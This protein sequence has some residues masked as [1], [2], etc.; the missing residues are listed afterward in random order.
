MEPYYGMIDY[1]VFLSPAFLELGM[2]AQSRFGQLIGTCDRM[3]VANL[4][5]VWN[6]NR[7]KADLMESLYKSELIWP[8]DAYY[9]FIPCV[10]NAN[11]KIRSGKYKSGF[12]KIGFQACVN[13]YPE[14]LQSMTD[15]EKDY[16][17]QH[18]IMTNE[19]IEALTFTQKPQAIEYNQASFEENNNDPSNYI[20][21][22]GVCMDRKD[23]T[24]Y[25]CLMMLY[26]DFEERN[27]VS[28]LTERDI[29]DW[30][31]NLY[32]NDYNYNGSKV[33]DLKKLFLGYLEKVMNNKRIQGNLYARDSYV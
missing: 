5:Y 18:G 1:R 33:N 8:V 10:Y 20:S 28:I 6:D 21:F 24:K 27:N 25:Q 4:Y 26:K 15:S 19:T 16:I 32:R 11:R 14:L 3:G 22:A 23:Y 30:F 29:T 13:K 12:D 31:M 9:C 17:K 7:I 2:E